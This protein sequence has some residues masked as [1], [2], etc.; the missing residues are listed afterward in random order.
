VTAEEL[1][2]VWS[3]L[4]TAGGTVSRNYLRHMIECIEVGE[5]RIT[6]VSRPEFAGV[7]GNPGGEM[8]GGGK[9]GVSA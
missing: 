2:R 3:T 5:N 9:T 4:V 1:P 8:I 7:A 6:I